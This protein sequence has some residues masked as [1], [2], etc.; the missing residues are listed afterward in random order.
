M[1]LSRETRKRRRLMRDR[2]RNTKLE[3]TLHDEERELED[4]VDGNEKKNKRWKV[5]SDDRETNNWDELMW[6]VIP[7]LNYTLLAF[8]LQVRTYKR[9]RKKSEKLLDFMNRSTA[10]SR[11][12][13]SPSLSG[14]LN[15]RA[16]RECN[17]WTETSATVTVFVGDC[18]VERLMD[19]M[20]GRMGKGREN[21]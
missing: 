21:G 6:S 15:F 7:G 20:R 16:N 4:W 19:G 1:N 17:S 11:T 8:S 5:E 9:F 10:S 12:T 2:R 3:L 14:F 13:P 18:D